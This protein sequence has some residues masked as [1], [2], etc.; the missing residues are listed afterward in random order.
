ME[1][2]LNA[3]GDLTNNIEGYLND[4]IGFRDKQIYY[5]TILNDKLFG[6]MVHPSYT[7]GK[8][9]YI[10]GAGIT[11]KNTFDDYHIVFAEMISKI[12]KYCNDRNV[13]FLFVFNPA[14]PAIYPD[15]L[16][17]G[18]NYNRDWVKL[19]FNELEKKGIN[20]LDNTETM[21][22][23]R[24]SGIQGFN[25]KYDASHWNDIGAF[26]GVNSI[27]KKLNTNNHTIPLNKE[28]DFIKSKDLKTSLQVSKFPIN[29]YVPNYILKANYRDITKIY[30]NDLKINPTYPGFGYY[31]NDSSLLTNTPKLLIFQGSYMNSYGK[32]YLINSFKE[33][34]HI[35]DYQNII[36]FPYY[37][38]IF[39]PECVIFEVAEY[40]FN[41]TYFNLEEMKKINYNPMVSVSESNN[42][43]KIDIQPDKITI[44]KGSKLTTI[45]WTSN[46]NYQYVYLNYNKIFD[47]Y[48]IEGGYQITLDL[49]SEIS[50]ESIQIYVI[51]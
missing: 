43:E 15:K 8:D 35:H 33:Y 18:I 14:K 11:T 47:M 21:N 5:Y 10:F 30:K 36:N 3:D 1:N 6:K 49:S 12:Q 48:K 46:D 9:G 34:I 24:Q 32:K 51:K 2:P 16:Y 26:Y 7:K 25:V 39:S 44:N 37:F 38:N 29:E 19:F 20:Y 40:T 42:L 23:L 41:S 31:I 50:K 4:R 17:E 13:P 28:N 22:L 27:I 45:T